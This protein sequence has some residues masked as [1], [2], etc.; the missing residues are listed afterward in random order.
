MR[1][2]IDSCQFETDYHAG[3]CSRAVS[4]LQCYDS[5]CVLAQL[6]CTACY[7]CFRWQIDADKL[8]F[9]FGHVELALW[10]GYSANVLR[11]TTA[12]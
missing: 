6:I 2:R 10:I 11:P 8:V 12:R 5:E 9:V 4:L 7:D 1:A 3:A